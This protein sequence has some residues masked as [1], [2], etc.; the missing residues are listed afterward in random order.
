MP[1]R[2]KIANGA[3]PFLTARLESR[4]GSFS[5]N[6]EFSL[7]APWTVLF[8]P[9]GAGKTSILRLLAGLLRPDRGSVTFRCS[10]LVDTAQGIFVPPGLR[11][12]GFVTQQ[13]ALFQHMTVAENVAFGLRKLPIAERHRR[14]EAMLHLLQA[15][16]LTNRRPAQLSGGEQQRVALARA[17][18]PEPRIVLLDEPF[19]ALDATL[20]E[21]ILPR[22]AA[23]LQ[24][25]KIPAFYVSHDLAEAF[26]T[27][28]EVIVMHEGQVA[29]QGSADDVLAGERTRLLR[30]LRAHSPI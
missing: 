12:I 10:T 22:L 5:L 6:T 19:S 8:G 2:I 11:S 13:P 15:E 27:A 9:S 20:K 21:R 24:E 30:N 17:L 7:W 1:D 18:A 28:A 29:A 16:S 3:D 26:Q 14:I 4:L 23:W 25:R